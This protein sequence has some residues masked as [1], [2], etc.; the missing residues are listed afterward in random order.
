MAINLTTEE[1]IVIFQLWPDQFSSKF[2]TVI[3]KTPL[4]EGV[5]V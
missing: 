5:V 2:D 3:P 1:K 4:Y